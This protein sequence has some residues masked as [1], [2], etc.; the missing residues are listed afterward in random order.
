[1]TNKTTVLTTTKIWS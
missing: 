1:M